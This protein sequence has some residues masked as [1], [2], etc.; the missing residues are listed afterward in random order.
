VIRI[1]FARRGPAPRRTYPSPNLPH[2]LQRGAAVMSLAVMASTLAVV[3][4]AEAG[5]A[6]AS[7]PWVGSS[8]APLAKANQVL[9]QM[10]LDEKISM[11]HGA[12]GARPYAGKIPAIARLCVPAIVLHDGPNGVGGL[13]PQVTQLPAPVAAAATFDTGLVRSYARG[14]ARSRRPRASRWR[15]PRW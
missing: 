3:A 8:A 13:L 5:R 7:C 4:P 14:K 1:S 11:V 10:T 15:W 12:P 6:A 9:A 2:R